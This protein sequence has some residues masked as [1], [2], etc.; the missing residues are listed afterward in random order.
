MPLASPNEVINLMI[1]Q[2]C[3]NYCN[4]LTRIALTHREG[5]LFFTKNRNIFS[6][7]DFNFKLLPGMRAEA[8]KLFTTLFQQVDIST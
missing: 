5:R 4:H 1:I 6:H 8:K 2:A 3:K 7:I